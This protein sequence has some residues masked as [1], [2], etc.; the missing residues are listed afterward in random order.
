[1]YI[2]PTYKACVVVIKIVATTMSFS[3]SVYI[4]E[5]LYLS[6]ESFIYR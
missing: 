2:N 1:M 6:L 3:L 4:K 5:T